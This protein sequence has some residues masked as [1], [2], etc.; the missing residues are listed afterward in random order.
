MY[1]IDKSKMITE[2]NVL[3]TKALFL[4][5]SY[6]NQ[7]NVCFVLSPHHNEERGLPSLYRLYLELE[8]L[9]EYTFAETY[10]LG[11]HHWRKLCECPWF[12][13]HLKLMRA[14]LEKKIKS[15]ALSQML[16]E[17]QNPDSKNYFQAL[18]YLADKGYKEKAEKGRPSK[19]QVSAAAKEEAKQ[20]DELQEI[21]ERLG[22]EKEL[23]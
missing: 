20:V 11:M 3:R 2:K 7:E 18:K 13:P 22:I 14:D 12:K 9:E 8:D 5:E 17:T 6:E 19:E 16:K 10:F 1:D 15:R 23:H 21:Y 4:E